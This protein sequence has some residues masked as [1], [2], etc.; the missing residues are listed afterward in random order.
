LRADDLFFGYPVFGYSIAYANIKAAVPYDQAPAWYR[1]GPWLR[2][3]NV[4]LVLKRPTF[5]FRFRRA[6]LWLADQA[7]PRFLAE[8]NKAIDGGTERTP[9]GADSEAGLQPP[10]GRT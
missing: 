1:N 9:T 6:D 4:V 5:W 10:G 7:A 3:P 2:P 8:V